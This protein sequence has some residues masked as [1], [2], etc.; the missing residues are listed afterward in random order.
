MKENPG[1]SA[2]KFLSNPSELRY[3]EPPK[4]TEIQKSE[5]LNF[6][7]ENLSNFQMLPMSFNSS[8]SIKKRTLARGEIEI[9]LI[10]MQILTDFF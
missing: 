2:S 9:K 10:F 6:F 7:D 3:L 8:S 1:P 5:D 4:K